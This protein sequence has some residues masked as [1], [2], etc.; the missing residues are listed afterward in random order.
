MQDVKPKRPINFSFS[1]LLILI[2]G[3]PLFLIIVRFTTSQIFY[4]SNG[5][6]KKRFVFLLSLGSL[7]YLIAL[8][9]YIIQSNE[10]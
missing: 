2:F 6:F 3:P 9:V 8:I 1:D 4:N 10:V 5:K 7:L